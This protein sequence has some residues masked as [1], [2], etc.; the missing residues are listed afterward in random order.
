MIQFWENLS[1]IA[2]VSPYAFFD[3]I[4]IS[5]TYHIKIIDVIVNY[6]FVFYVRDENK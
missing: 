4:H 5:H 3:D 2:S 6:F 1:I